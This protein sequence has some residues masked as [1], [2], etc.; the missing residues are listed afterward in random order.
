MIKILFICMGNICRSPTAEAI[1]Q[2]IVDRHAWSE[3][4][5]IDS[6]ATHGYHIG[7]RADARMIKHAQLR[8]Y[9]LTSISRQ[10]DY[11]QDLQ[12]FNYI[13]VMD[14]N[15]YTHITSFDVD[16]R[17]REKIYKMTDFCRHIE[18]DQVP[19]PY[20]GGDAGFEQVLDILEDA[21]QGL[22]DRISR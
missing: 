12:D 9:V 3:K 17:Y 15:N 7:H 16:N 11:P 10:F 13:V 4:V 18:M 6:C 21:C 20:Y 2:A 19:D 5:F 8:G 22:F 14:D 1:M